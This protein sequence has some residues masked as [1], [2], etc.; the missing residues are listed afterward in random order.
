MKYLFLIISILIT[1]EGCE[2]KTQSKNISFE[3]SAV[4]RGIFNKININ[5]KESSLQ[6]SPNGAIKTIPCPKANWSNLLNALKNIDIT[7]IP[8]LE[9]PSKAHQYDGAAIANL[10]LT[11]DGKTFETVSFDHGNPPK[12]IEALVK[13]ILSIAQNIE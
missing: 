2:N 12:E 4:S 1:N 5:E 13:E 8:K 6:D 7:N 3:Y 11:I 10:I 9:A